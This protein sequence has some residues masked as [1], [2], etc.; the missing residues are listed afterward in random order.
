MKMV[1]HAMAALL[2]L[3]SGAHAAPA[4][5]D[6]PLGAV[7][8]SVSLNPLHN[9]EI[10]IRRT[11]AKG[12]LGLITYT[13]ALFNKITPASE[14]DRPMQEVPGH[15]IDSGLEPQLGTIQNI[16]YKPLPPGKYVITKLLVT[17]RRTDFYWFS[18]EDIAFEV[19]P[20]ANT[21]LGQFE[22]IE[23][24]GKS[25]IGFSYPQGWF[26]T[27]TD[28]TERDQDWIKIQHPDAME[29]RSSVPA[30]WNREP[31]FN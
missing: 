23:L 7:S 9:A 29:L 17:D 2:L 31:W 13:S 5:K 22:W 11:D 30:T 3:A 16:I 19:A 8:M 6:A 12:K 14:S 25:K 21:Y 20:G 26:F 24:W 15:L 10:S 27:I 18:K 1:I 4:Q 28:K